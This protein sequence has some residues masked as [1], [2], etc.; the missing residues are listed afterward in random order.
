MKNVKIVTDDNIRVDKRQIHGLVRDVKL[1]EN[2]SISS[3]QINIL[4]DEYILELNRKYLEHDYNT[5]II[6]FNYSGSHEILD[7]E[8]FIS[9]QDALGNAIKFNVHLDIEFLRLIIHG[10][11][12]LLG[13]DDTSARDKK[14]M[15][16]KEN[17]LVECFQSKY[18]NIII[19]YDC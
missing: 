10:I 6:T 12:H 1:Q 13:F 17:E 9:F 3:L 5:D 4:N 2:F 16:K 19:T 11:L 18:R 7:G 15:L 14:I 8:I